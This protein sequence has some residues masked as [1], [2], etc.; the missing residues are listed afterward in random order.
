VDFNIPVS[1]IRMQYLLHFTTA[2]LENTISSRPVE[3][4]RAVADRCI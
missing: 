4:F 2:K 3:V 1:R